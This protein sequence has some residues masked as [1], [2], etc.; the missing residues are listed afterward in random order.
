[1]QDT[2]LVIAGKR[3]GS[4]LILGTGKYRTLE[5]MKQALIAAQPGMVTVAIRRVDMNDKSSQSFWNFLPEG[6]NVRR[7]AIALQLS[8]QST[9][10]LNFSLQPYLIMHSGNPDELARDNQPPCRIRKG[11]RWDLYSTPDLGH[12]KIGIHTPC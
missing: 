12:R 8:R 11:G 4:R 2:D 1:M 5:L 6:K 9:G 3:Y 10:V 7:K